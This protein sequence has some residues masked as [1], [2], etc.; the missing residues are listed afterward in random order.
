M[1]GR[2]GLAG[3]NQQGV[4][5]MK[6]PYLIALTAALI[7]AGAIKAAPAFAEPIDAQTY[8]SHVQTRDLD[9]SSASGTRELQQ[10]LT[11]AAREVCG[12]AS[13]ADIAG[14]NDVRKCRD[15]ALARATNDRAALL[16]A[17][18][19]GAVLAVTAAR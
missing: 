9:L 16:A 8:V 13:D 2:T 4:A 11:L 5:T 1:D 7:T 3:P 18:S 12:V 10:R 17:A 19:R 15:D 14:K 6:N